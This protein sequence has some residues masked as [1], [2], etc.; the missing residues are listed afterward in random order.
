MKR[1][2]KAEPTLWSDCTWEELEVRFAS[3]RDLALLPVGATEQHGPHLGTGMDTCLAETV[4]HEV[5]RRTGV[6]VMPTLAYGC[7]LGHSRRWSGTLP[8]QPQTLQNIIVDL[9]SWAAET[10][11]GRLL[12]VNSHVT[13]AAPLRCAVEILRSRVDHLL[14]GIVSTAATSPEVAGIFASDAQDW[15]ANRAETSLMMALAPRLVRPE[16]LPRA[17]DP[18]RTK[19]LVFVHPVNRT[20]RNGVTGAPSKA[21]ATE[22]RRLFRRIVEDL[23]TIVRKAE[24]E[25]PPLPHAFGHPRFQS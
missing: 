19:G 22:G 9:G 10:G 24:K 13:N 12:I 3:G 6:L 23:S 4:C 11:L 2:R 1:R 15:H 20:S 8:L 17:D 7:S 18:D 25:T 14:T 5:S 21:T 16:S